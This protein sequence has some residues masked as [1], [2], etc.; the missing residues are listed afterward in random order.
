M[1]VQCGD[2]IVEN[3]SMVQLCGIGH[4]Q[5]SVPGALGG[6]ESTESINTH[7]E[8]QVLNP[9]TQG[10]LRACPG[11]QAPQG[12]LL[13]ETEVR[14]EGSLSPGG[15]A[16]RKEPYGA[17]PGPNCRPREKRPPGALG[18]KVSRSKGGRGSPPGRKALLGDRITIA[19]GPGWEDFNR[20]PFFS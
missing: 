12:F 6:W 10:T 19:P 14:G 9:T 5:E 20:A 17:A 11:T 13:T 1:H 2:T 15:V 7:P 4:Q 18:I 3:L 8:G 16:M